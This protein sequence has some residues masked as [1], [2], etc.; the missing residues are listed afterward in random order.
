MKRK[1]VKIA[2]ENYVFMKNIDMSIW[3]NVNECEYK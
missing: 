2:V 1:R 3:K